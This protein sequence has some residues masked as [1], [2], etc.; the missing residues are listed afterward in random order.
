MQNLLGSTAGIKDIMESL[1]GS[2]GPTPPTA[3]QILTGATMGLD[4][5]QTAAGTVTPAE[6]Q[7]EL[8][9]IPD[10]Y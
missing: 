10:D 8:D 1:Y 7:A 5:D 6:T 3:S 2:S 4:Y 9:S